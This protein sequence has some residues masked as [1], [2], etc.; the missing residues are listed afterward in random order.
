MRLRKGEKAI[1]LSS[2]YNHK[3][4]QI[5]TRN[6]FLKLNRIEYQRYRLLKMKKDSTSL[7]LK[8]GDSVKVKEGL[9]CPD[10]EDL[11][12]GGWQGTILE[13]G[14]DDSGNDLI[15]IRWDSITLKNMPRYFI[16]RSEEERFE[17]ARMYLWPEDVELAECRDTEEDAA[18]ALAESSKRHSWSW[19]GEEGK[20][21]RKVL[22]DVDEK[23]I[24]ESLKAWQK[25]LEKTLSFPFDAVVSGYQDKGP[26]QS[27]DRV[28]VKKISIV[29]DL[30]GVIVELRR[31]R[32]KYHHPL[33]DLEVINEDS[34]NDQPVKDYCVWFANQ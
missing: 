14:E 2:F 27:G 33:C 13:I 28:S 26:L 5:L 29:D 9:M 17:Y 12:I 16:D 7:N 8:I 19:L 24:M 25:Y 23:D 3:I 22:A 10:S 20:R 4:T 15:C 21:I 11:C 34:A 18:K 6:L 32:K 30:Y 1:C 31:G